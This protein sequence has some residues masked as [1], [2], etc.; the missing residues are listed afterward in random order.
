MRISRTREY[1]A[2]CNGIPSVMHA[3]RYRREV[4]IDALQS[5]EGR[6]AAKRKEGVIEGDGVEGGGRKKIA[7]SAFVGTRLNGLAASG[8]QSE[9]RVQIPAHKQAHKYGVRTV[10]IQEGSCYRA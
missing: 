5:G 4:V 8:R 2:W 9:P 1:A 3:D 6:G 7:Q 10:C